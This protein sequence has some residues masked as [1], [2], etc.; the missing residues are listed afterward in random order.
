MCAMRTRRTSLLA[1]LA[2]VCGSTSVLT[3][4][5][6]DAATPT[7]GPRWCSIDPAPPCVEHLYV[8]GFEKTAADVAQYGHY[9]TFIEGEVGFQLSMHKDGAYNVLDTGDTYQ[10]VVDTGTI[11]PAVA[12]GHGSNIAI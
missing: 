10:A 2:L 5:G 7:Q 4:G 9:F 12:T 11:V 3:A 1:A 6:A 8:N